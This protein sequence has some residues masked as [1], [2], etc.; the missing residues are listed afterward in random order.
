MK[1]VIA[2]W[3][4][5]L[6][7]VSFAENRPWTDEEKLLGATALTLHAIDTSQTSYGMKHGYRELN[8]ILGS[9]PSDDKL[10][11]FF[12]LSTLGA[13]HVLDTYEE[14][15]KIGLYWVI[16]VKSIVVRRHIGMGLKVRF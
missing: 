7:N 5:L 9:H 3:L 15:R 2:L 14:D 6:M 4:C 12:V 13:Y 1:L 16:G 10:A 8:P 11:A